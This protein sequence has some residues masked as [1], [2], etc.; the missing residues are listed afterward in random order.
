MRASLA[1]VAARKRQRLQAM[2]DQPGEWRLVRSVWIAVYAAPDGRHLELH[3][4]SERG[5]WVRVGSERA[6][7]GALAKL[8]WR[9]TGTARPAPPPRAG[10]DGNAATG[11]R[12]DV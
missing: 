8:L 10:G 7:R 4:A 11:R 5:H 3:A 6:V 2:A 9:M 1:G 12:S